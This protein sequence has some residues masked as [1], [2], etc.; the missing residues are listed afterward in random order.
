MLEEAGNRATQRSAYGHFHRS[1]Q[2]ETVHCRPGSPTSQQAIST[3]VSHPWIL[4]HH[5]VQWVSHL[6]VVL[7][8]GHG[9]RLQFWQT[10]LPCAGLWLS[11][12]VAFPAGQKKKKNELSTMNLN[13]FLFC[14]VISF[15][16]RWPKFAAIV[17]SLLSARVP[18][19]SHHAK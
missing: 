2:V 17:L 19:I 9:E 16:I 1:Q 18:G 14:F 8:P 13:L 5:L 3:L 4:S 11:W 15:E 10:R 12:W 7:F 6:L